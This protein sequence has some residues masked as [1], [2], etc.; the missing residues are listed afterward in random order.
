MNNSS[1]RPLFYRWAGFDIALCL[2]FG[3]GALAMMVISAVNLQ[4]ILVSSGNA[5]FIEDEYKSWLI[6]VL[7]PLL[8]IGIKLVPTAFEYPQNKQL[9]FKL[10]NILTA[11]TGLV[12]IILIATT[13]EG[14]GT[15]FSIDD[16]LVPDSEDGTGVAYVL[17]QILL[18]IMLSSVLFQ[19]CS[20]IVEKYQPQKPSP[21]ATELRKD[22]ALLDKRIADISAQ[23]LTA[24]RNVDS[25]KTHCAVFIN[26]NL[27]KLRLK[28]A[29]FDLFTKFF[30]D[31]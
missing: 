20:A 24:T 30:G 13:F 9:Y 4:A 27:D 1:Y 17:V 28:R 6:A 5:V 16:L 21:E 2:L 23:V 8:A 3:F 14:L 29:E 31:K 12:W 19:A 7:A 15:D 26:T 22:I 18:E 10:L 25:H 11:L